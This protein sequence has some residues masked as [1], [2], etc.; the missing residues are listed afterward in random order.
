M[1]G[2]WAQ[3]L[4][5][6]AILLACT[7]RWASPAMLEQVYEPFESPFRLTDVQSRYAML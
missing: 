6:W 4:A 7:T 2:L 3:R 5:A 1:L